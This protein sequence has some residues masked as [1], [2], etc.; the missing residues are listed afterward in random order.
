MTTTEAWLRLTR[1]QRRAFVEKRLNPI[2]GRYA[3][4]VQPRHI[5]AE[6]FTARCT[7]VLILEVSDLRQYYYFMEELRDTE[8]YTK[9]YFRVEEII[10]GV[11]N[12]FAEFEEQASPKP[13][14]RT[15]KAPRSSAPK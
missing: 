6:A 1:T 4:S 8:V 5:D 2:F 10:V 12:G 13:S 15:R 9:P 3:A 11:E 14:K 7:D